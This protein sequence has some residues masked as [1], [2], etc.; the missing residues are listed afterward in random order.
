MK[1]RIA[2]QFR[3]SYGPGWHYGGYDYLQTLEWSNEKTLYVKVEGSKGT[4]L[5]PLTFAF[6]IL[7][8]GI[9]EEELKRKWQEKWNT[10]RSKS[11]N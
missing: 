10:L 9:G 6:F 7:K 11:K 8:G 2:F 5:A 4:F 1:G 3:N